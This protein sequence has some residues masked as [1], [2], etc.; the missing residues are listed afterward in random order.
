MPRS[1][2]QSAH[3]RWLGTI[4]SGLVAVSSWSS[5]AL[6]E[7]LLFDATLIPTSAITLFGVVLLCLAWLMLL[8]QKGHSY[9]SL[10]VTYFWWAAPL[11]V[12]APLFSRDVYSYLAQGAA[13]ARG[14]DPYAAGPLALLGTHDPLAKAVDSLWAT[15][16]SPYGPVATG[17]S[18]VIATLS[19]EHMIAGIALHR[20][21]A[22]G[23]TLA[24]AWSLK[25]PHA[26]LLG[27]LNPLALIHFVGGAHNDAL[28]LAFVLVGLKIALRSSSPS[29]ALG[30]AALISAGGLVKSAGLPALGFA[31]MVLARRLKRRGIPAPILVAAAVEASVL[32]GTAFGTS[33]MTDTGFGWITAQTASAQTNSWLSITSLI[34]RALGHQH[35]AQAIGLVLAGAVMVVALFATYHARIHPLGGLGLANLGMVALFPV[36]QPWYPLWAIVVLA[37]WGLHVASRSK[38]L[39]APSVLFCFLALPRGQALGAIEVAAIYLLAATLCVIG[40]FLMRLVRIANH[41]RS[42]RSRFRS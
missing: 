28:M 31:G 39:I 30:G 17:I 15:T 23:A 7:P 40:V 19:Q 1:L 35:A 27:V 25:S 24:I 10:M 12:A 41:G 6:P 26:L 32:A 29:S 8:G 20:A 21:V 4:G 14:L 5:G 18:G 3:P 22:F 11:L 37:G 16:P 13:V 2:L 42:A 36:V 9:R 34:G 33:A 38:K